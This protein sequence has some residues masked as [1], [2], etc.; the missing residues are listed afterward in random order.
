MP[1]ERSK[2]SISASSWLSVCSR[3]SFVD[4]RPAP[5]RWPIASTS[6]MK[7]IAGR[8]LPRLGE[9]VAH[10]RGSDADEHLDEARAGDRE[11]RHPGLA[12]N[13]PG[14][15]R[16]AGARRADHQHA[17]RSHRARLR[18]ALGVIEEV[19]DLADL[20]LRALVAGHVAESGR[21][22]LRVVDLRARA[23][24]PADPARELA[25]RSPADVQVHPDQQQEG[26]EAEDHAEYARPGLALAGDLD[27]ARLEL[28]RE[29]GVLEGDRDLGRVVPTVL[30]RS[31]DGAA[32][33]DHG[34]RYLA[35]F[36][37]ER[38]SV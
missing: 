14:Q 5:R 4:E 7:M 13:G 2:P 8:P 38:N 27:P 19:D 11:E 12:G 3:S 34:R 23:D 35:G 28:L 32:G 18:V 6:S 37:R 16:L 22:G 20:L 36:T 33:I 25:L 21:R 1:V 10:P 9:Q 31:G 30:E 29:I 15:Q 26:Q 24:D 17:S